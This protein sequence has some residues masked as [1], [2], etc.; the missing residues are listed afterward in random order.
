MLSFMINYKQ[1]TGLLRV[2]KTLCHTVIEVQ[3]NPWL[4]SVTG[5]W[6]SSDCQ[7]YIA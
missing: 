2:K 1:S 7:F 5:R 6:I 3:G 4:V